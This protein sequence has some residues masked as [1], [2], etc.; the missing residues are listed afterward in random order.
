MAVN[1]PKDVLENVLDSKLM[2]ELQKKIMEAIRPTLELIVKSLIAP[3]KE[4]LIQVAKDTSSEMVNEKMELI[5]QKMQ[6]LSQENNVLK[7]RVETAECRTNRCSLVFAGLGE[8]NTSERYRDQQKIDGEMIVHLLNE[9]LGIMATEN[10]ISNSFRIPNG[11]MGTC[12][13][14]VV[15]FTTRRLRDQIYRA[16]KQ[17]RN[18]SPLVF[19]NE[20]LTKQS[21]KLFALAR[22][23]V[24]RK[25][26]FST[27]TTEGTVMVKVND[28]ITIKPIRILDISAL[29]IYDPDIG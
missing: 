26:I 3:M 8:S 14:L 28:E 18:G 23:L 21:A 17:L 5:N 2:E 22:Q 15:N 24:R 27:W 11:K 16:R 4:E 9:K 29:R 6:K 25:L 12:R 20:L 7:Q 13:A 19:I 1:K 10:D